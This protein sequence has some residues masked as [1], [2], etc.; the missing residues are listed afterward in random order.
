M[1]IPLY[2]HH[3]SLEWDKLLKHNLENCYIIINPNDGP[4]V[5]SEKADWK[6]LVEKIIQK[7]GKIVVYI[8]SFRAVYK[9]KKWVL[10]PKSYLNLLE[11]HV[12]YE[13]IFGGKNISGVFLDDY[14]AHGM[15]NDAPVKFA[16]QVQKLLIL[17][18]GTKVKEFNKIFAYPKNFDREKTVWLEHETNKIPDVTLLNEPFIALECSTYPFEFYSLKINK[19]FY[20]HTQKDGANPYEKLSPHFIQMQMQR[21]RTE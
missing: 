3:S 2:A 4:C 15:M 7:K 20:V 5:F 14:P 12:K 1:L 18:P 9:D 21:Q 10:N 13:K 11:E 8:D 19:F 16:R 17:N 6:S